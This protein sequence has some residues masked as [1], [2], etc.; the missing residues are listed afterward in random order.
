MAR[1]ED[2][3]ERACFEVLGHD[4]LGRE[5][6]SLARNQ[7]LAGPNGRVLCQ[8]HAQATW[9]TVCA[10]TWQTT[11]VDKRAE[12]MDSNVC[13][14]PGAHESDDA[15]HTHARTETKKDKNVKMLIKTKRNTW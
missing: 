3:D 7:Q 9:T 2:L 1:G 12:L 5:V 13:G 11:L 4:E 15:H 6:R 8:T 14:S 10:A